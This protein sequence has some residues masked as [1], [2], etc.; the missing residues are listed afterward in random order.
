VHWSVGVA[1]VVRGLS[2]YLAGLSVFAAEVLGVVGPTKSSETRE[3]IGGADQLSHWH[4]IHTQHQPHPGQTG[5]RLQPVS[6]WTTSSLMS[7]SRKT[8]VCIQLIIDIFLSQPSRCS[9]DATLKRRCL[10]HLMTRINIVQRGLKRDKYLCTSGVQHIW[11]SNE[12]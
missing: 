9:I 3:G 1:A 5:S 11:K 12:H 2:G 4:Y 7:L 6:P 10:R 8:I